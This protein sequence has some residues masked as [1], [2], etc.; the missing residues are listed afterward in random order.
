MDFPESLDIDPHHSE[1][2]FWRIDFS[3]ILFYFIVTVFGIFAFWPFLLFCDWP[4]VF[5]Y[6]KFQTYRKVEKV[7]FDTKISITHVL[8]LS[9]YRISFL[10]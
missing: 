1:V 10:M 4:F 7:Y 2:S 3:I 9:F 8:Q 6:K 5:Y